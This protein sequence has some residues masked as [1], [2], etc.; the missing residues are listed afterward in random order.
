MW[1]G[2]RRRM[3]AQISGL[4]LGRLGRL[5]IE[6]IGG[7]VWRDFTVRRLIIYDDKGTWLDARD[8]SIRWHYLELIT[9]RVH[10][11]AMA[12][13]S[14]TV[15]RRPFLGPK[16]KSNPPP[17]SFQIDAARARV[18]LLPAF[19][20]RRGVYDVTTRFDVQRKGGAPR[21]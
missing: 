21:V 11:D 9:R 12:A 3:E 13:R 17:V 16:S 20:Y 4:K 10:V 18:D 15:I 14:V 2:G 8:V 19:S 7:D 6:G 5:R 1:A